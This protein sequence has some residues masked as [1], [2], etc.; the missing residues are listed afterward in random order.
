MKN[1]FV[2]LLTFL[3]L[4]PAHAQTLGPFPMNGLVMI[5]YQAFVSNGTY[6]PDPGTQEIY[7]TVIGQGGGGGGCAS[8][9][10]VQNCVAGSGGAGSYAAVYILSPITETITVGTSGAGG[11]AGNNN[12]VHGSTVSFGSLISC[13]GGVA[14]AG[15][16]A[17][18]ATTPTITTTTG[19]APTAC[20]ISGSTNYVTYPGQYPSPSES[21][22]VLS[23]V[24]SPPGGLSLYGSGGNGV[25]VNG[26][27]ADG[28]GLGSGGSGA[29]SSNGGSAVAGGNPGNGVIIVEEYGQ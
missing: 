16:A 24:F 9:S 20:T 1:A 13:P 21:L 8:T 23:A 18:T 25:S 11:A 28:S 17:F 3:G 6:T 7:V 14:G 2:I 26:A 4:S 22:G 5:G 19:I 10:V 12:G 15:S 27:G 29:V